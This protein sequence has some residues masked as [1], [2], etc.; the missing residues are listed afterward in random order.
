MEKVAIVGIG[1]S[2]KKIN[3][4]KVFY[5][6]AYEAAKQALSQA[7][8]EKGDIENVVLA[9]YDISLGRTIS[10]MYVVGSA[11]GYLKDEIKVADD[12]IY[13]L[14][15]GYMRVLSGLGKTMVLA[16]GINSES[17]FELVNNLILD[18]LFHRD[19]G[20]SFTTALALQVSAYKEKYNVSEKDSAKVVIKNRKKVKLKDVLNSPYEAYPLKKMEIAEVSDGCVAV[21]LCSEEEARR[22]I[23]EPVWI[24]GIYWCNDNY[25]M[26]SKEITEITSLK[27]CAEKIY[28][29]CGIK[30]PL[31]EIDVFEVTELTS[32]H[33]LMIYEALGLCKEGEGKKLIDQFY[34]SHPPVVNPSGGALSYNPYCATGLLRVVEVYLQLTNKAGKN[35]IKNAKRGLAHGHYGFAY[36]GNCLV[37]L[38]V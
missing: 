35:Q 27:I 21:I 7:G 18:P 26:G 6:L 9:G 10:N 15:L 12:G 14:A 1:T 4:E 2:R 33:E 37:M 3:N 34:R 11:C 36:Q 23:P 32:Y 20:L 30:E 28:K 22:V 29:R 13:A 31:K 24:T 17:P 8:L 38:E 16:Y 25:F 19:T 5:D